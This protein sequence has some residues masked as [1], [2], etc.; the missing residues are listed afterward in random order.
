MIHLASG[1]SQLN[2]LERF[3]LAVMVEASGLLVVEAPSPSVVTLDISDRPGTTKTALSPESGDG[4]IRVFREALAELGAVAGAVKEQRS[5]EQ[6]RHGR[7]PSAVN[8]MVEAGVHQAP[9][10]NLAGRALREAVVAQA[11]TR[12]VR[13]MA[14]WPRG[15]R[16]AAAFT[17]D[18][19]VV[20]GWPL[21]TTLRLAELAGKGEVGLALQVAGAALK[22]VVADPVS[23]GVREILGTE[24]ELGI[25]STWFILAGEPSLGSISRG[26]VTYSL[27]SGR[28]QRILDSVVAGGHEIGLHG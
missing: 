12:L 2:P 14:P 17:H 19:D 1:T 11:S 4:E 24:R 15:R 26:D 6:D 5:T 10:I 7:V 8:P 23:R 28:A 9:R 22:S 16:W 25:V 21:F 18:L 3:G 13:V 27:G 20:S